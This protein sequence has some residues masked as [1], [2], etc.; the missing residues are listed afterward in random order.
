M[1]ILRICRSGVLSVLILNILDILLLSLD[2]LHYIIDLRLLKISEF[3][4]PP[5]KEA[6]ALLRRLLPSQLN[7]SI[8]IISIQFLVYFKTVRIGTSQFLLRS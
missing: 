4:L 6:I 7:R 1:I 2:L 3:V 8:N 5:V